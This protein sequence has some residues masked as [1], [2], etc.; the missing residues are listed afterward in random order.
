LE[1]I[2]ILL[3]WLTGKGGNDPRKKGGTHLLP[4]SMAK[5]EKRGKTIVVCERHQE[6]S[7]KGK[8]NALYGRTHTCKPDEKGGKERD[9]DFVTQIPPWWKEEARRRGKIS[10]HQKTESVQNGGGNGRSVM[11][12]GGGRNSP[13]KGK[14]EGSNSYNNVSV[15]AANPICSLKKKN[16]HV[17]RCCSNDPGKKEEGRLK[18]VTG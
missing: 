16:L 15:P 8:R 6:H 11:Q 1:K 18:L 2:E 17:L 12:K 13:R 10:Y 4:K 3:K 5:K 7:A 14:R 9:S